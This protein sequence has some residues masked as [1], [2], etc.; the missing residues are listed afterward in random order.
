[1]RC[2]LVVAC[3][4]MLALMPGAQLKGFVTRI[5]EVPVSDI[6]VVAMTE[7]LDRAGLA[8]KSVGSALQTEHHSV[9]VQVR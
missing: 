9:V 3:S 8:I 5:R 7:M 4:A 6:P 1:M 2:A